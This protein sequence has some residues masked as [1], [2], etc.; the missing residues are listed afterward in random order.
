VLCPP[1]ARSV[2]GSY[3]KSHGIK[4]RKEE[5]PKRRILDDGALGPHTPPL[6][7]SKKI[8]WKVE[9]LKISR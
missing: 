9:V 7:L 4:K 3:G 2:F 5:K 1:S 8:I 6:D